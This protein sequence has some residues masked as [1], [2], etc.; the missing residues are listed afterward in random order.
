ML[1]HAVREGAAR[2]GPHDHPDVSMHTHALARYV[3]HLDR[4]DWEGVGGLMLSSA[5][6][7]A[8]AGA[9]FLICPDNTIHQA[10]ALVVPRSPLPWLHIAEVVAGRAAERGLRR[11]GS[12]APDGWWRARSTPARSRRA[13]WNTCSPPARSARRSTA[14]SW[15]SWS[16]ASSRPRPWPAS[17]ASSAA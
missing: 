2:L 7:L 3:E 5:R 12:P 17:S 11:V 15:R 1:P 9:D 16:A 10:M 13:A 6:A 8:A 4:G 14:S